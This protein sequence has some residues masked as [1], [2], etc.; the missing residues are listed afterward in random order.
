MAK[1]DF[2]DFYHKIKFKTDP[3]N[4]EKK[5]GY[6]CIRTAHETLAYT[7]SPMGL[8]SMDVFQDELTDCLFGDLVLS[9]KL[10][11]IADNIYFG[12]DTV[13]DLSSIFLEII[14]REHI[15]NL[16]IKPNKIKIHIKSTDILGLLWKRG[17]LTPSKHKLD[18]L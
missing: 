8:L 9:G 1:L 13:S 15:S 17:T 18:P 5:L 16:H 14:K 10:C 2:I 12:G 4:D 6:L 3:V 7:Q 11:K